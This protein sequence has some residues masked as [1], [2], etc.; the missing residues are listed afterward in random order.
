MEKNKIY[1]AKGKKTT[2]AVT[3]EFIHTKID[4]MKKLKKKEVSISGKIPF[5]L[6]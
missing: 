3:N 1:P 4:E 2:K 5:F 6:K